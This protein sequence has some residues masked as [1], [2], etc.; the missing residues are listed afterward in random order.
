MNN[1][2]KEGEHFWGYEFFRT[3]GISTQNWPSHALSLGV[4]GPNQKAGTFPTVCEMTL[5]REISLQWTG[6]RF[7]D[8]SAS[9]CPRLLLHLLTQRPSYWWAKYKMSPLHPRHPPCHHFLFQ[10]LLLRFWILWS[11]QGLELLERC[12]TEESHSY[13]NSVCVN[14]ANG[15]GSTAV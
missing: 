1:P 6:H 7:L 3:T 15:S 14:P 9:W 10:P 5:W 12:A 11:V 13:S 4:P 8:K 2:I